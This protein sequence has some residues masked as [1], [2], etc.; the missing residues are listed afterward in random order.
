MEMQELRQAINEIK[1]K[2]G[3]NSTAL[4]F[5]IKTLSDK[6]VKAE[7]NGKN[8]TILDNAL[9]SDIV[10]SLDAFRTDMILSIMQLEKAD[11]TPLK[12][13]LNNET[14]LSSINKIKDLTIRNFWLE[15]YCEKILGRTLSRK[16]YATESNNLPKL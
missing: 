3:K 13:V 12:Q 7:T 16:Y 14:E 8:Y 11:S 1:P 9:I 10:G 15:K 2:A 4:K 5:I 6:K